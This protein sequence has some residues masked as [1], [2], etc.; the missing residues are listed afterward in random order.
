MQS[1]SMALS[2]VPP[3]LCKAVPLQTHPL[4]PGFYLTVKFK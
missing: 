4:V 1:F 2:A 3:K